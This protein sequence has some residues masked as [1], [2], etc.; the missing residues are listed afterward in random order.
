[1][2]HKLKILLR[3]I[4][5]KHQRLLASYSKI[6]KINISSSS[7]DSHSDSS[8]DQK[9]PKMLDNS[10]TKQEKNE[11]LEKFIDEHMSHDLT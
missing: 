6:S 10:I 7:N 11:A 1:M 9:M 3:L 2:Q 5:S 4:L 8:S